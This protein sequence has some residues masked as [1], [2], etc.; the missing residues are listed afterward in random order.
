MPANLTDW[1]ALLERRHGTVVDLGLDRIVKIWR[2][3]GCPRPAPRVFV[4]AGTNGKGSTVATLCS[5][6]GSLG[7]RYGSYTS[8]HIE[9]YNERVRVNGEAE[10]D[11]SLI[12]AFKNVEAARGDCKLSYF[13]FGTLAA[14]DRLSRAELD[15]AVME[16]GLGGRLDAVNLLDADCAVITPI[17]LDHQE[18]LG[19]DLESIGREKAGIIRHGK[20]VICGESNPPSS[21]IETARALNAPIK[22]LGREFT[23][24]AQKGRVFFSLADL[25]L[26]LPL[27]VL[28]GTHQVNN[29]ATAVAALLE[30]VPE[31]SGQPAELADGVRGVSLRGRFE[32]VVQRPPVWV[33]VGHNPL[34]AKAAAAALSEACSRER[35]KTVRCV[36]AMLADKDAVGVARELI[37]AVDSFHCAGLVADRGQTGDQLSARLTEAGLPTEI[38]TFERVGQAIDSALAASSSGDAV[39]VFGS[40]YTAAEALAHLRALNHDNRPP[41][42]LES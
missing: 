28:D 32:R 11:R 4:V 1:L 38:R 10:S 16:I 9:A 19:A 13:E 29:M 17:G 14:I 30:L 21:V 33:D 34:G 26:D 25:R 6:L 35:I 31:A 2:R 22:R 36:L 23:I 42:L 5:L 37:P 12:A 27:P 39:F 7:Y 20:P 41:M 8:P 24:E 3:M 15:F 18:Y 40:F